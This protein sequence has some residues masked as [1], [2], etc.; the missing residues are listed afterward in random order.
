MHIWVRGT[1]NGSSHAQF[2]NASWSE[3]TE[4]SIRLIRKGVLRH[5]ARELVCKLVSVV[6][7]SPFHETLHKNHQKSKN[8]QSL[9]PW[10]CGRGVLTCSGWVG[11]R[12]KLRFHL[13]CP[14]PNGQTSNNRNDKDKIRN[15]RGQSKPSRFK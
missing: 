3:T 15:S 2:K 14:V 12:P 10:R 4:I 13:G 1:R 11:T 5:E 6:V 9:S 7:E 8:S